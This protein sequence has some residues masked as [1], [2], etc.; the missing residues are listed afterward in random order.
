M[1]RRTYTPTAAQKDAARAKRAALVARSVPIQMARKAGLLPYAEL[2]TVNACLELQYRA[3]SGQEEFHTFQGWKEIG[4]SVDKGSAG[5]A[6]WGKP[7]RAEAEGAS[8]AAEGFTGEDAEAARGFSFFP[9]CYLFNAAQVHNAA[10]ER[11]ASYRTQAESDAQQCRDILAAEHLPEAIPTPEPEPTPTA[12]DSQH[13]CA[14]CFST[15]H[16]GLARGLCR[17]CREGS[18]TMPLFELLA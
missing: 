6:I 16:D 12:E 13:A 15:A 5:F 9:I 14:R 4:F 18:D 3:E 7:L 17:D 11:P 1:K 10:G 8:E 2:P